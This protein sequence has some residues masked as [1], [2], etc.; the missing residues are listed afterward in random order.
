MLFPKPY[1]K[2]FKLAESRIWYKIFRFHCICF[3]IQLTFKSSPAMLVSPF[4][5]IDGFT[6]WMFRQT[7]MSTIHYTVPFFF[8]N[9]RI[10]EKMT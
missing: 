1:F 9:K 7:Q 5:I 2:R 4:F 10:T 6:S 8:A 3:V